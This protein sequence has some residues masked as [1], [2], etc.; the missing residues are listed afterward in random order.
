MKRLI[1]KSI[2]RGNLLNL[3]L[4]NQDEPVKAGKVDHSLGCSNRKM[5]I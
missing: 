2:R 4:I 1:D 5:V 3:L